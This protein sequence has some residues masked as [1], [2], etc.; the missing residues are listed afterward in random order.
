MKRTTPLVLATLLLAGCADKAFLHKESRLEPRLTV[1]EGMAE[2]RDLG[3]RDL[4]LIGHDPKLY[5]YRPSDDERR[6]LSEPPTLAV[7]E[8]ERVSA[9][10]SLAV[11]LEHQEG[12][13]Y[14]AI[15]A[16]FPESWRWTGIALAELGVDVTDRDRQRGIYYV[17]L[18]TGELLGD[19][20]GW[21]DKMFDDQDERELR[22]PHL[23]GLQRVGTDRVRLLLL[24]ET[25]KPIDRPYAEQALTRLRDQLAR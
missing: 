16:G 3:A 19:S 13:A 11:S 1:P 4:A 25:G 2:P 18:A 5:E 7:V 17:N 6:Q 22:R 14:L 9:S 21:F 24:D 20:A 23:I 15:L 8:P 12:I 10:A